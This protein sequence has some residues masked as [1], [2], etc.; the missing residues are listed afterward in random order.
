MQVNTINPSVSTA[1][2]VAT[3]NSAKSNGRLIEYFSLNYNTTKS[4]ANAKATSENSFVAFL[5]VIGNVAMTAL[6]AVG[7]TFA[8]ALKGSFNLGVSPLNF[9]YSL[10]K[11]EEKK[12]TT[13]EVAEEAPAPSAPVLEEKEEAEVAPVATPELETVEE[14]K[15]VTVELPKDSPRSILT[16]AKDRLAFEGTR[17]KAGLNF[18]FTTGK[19]KTVYAANQAAKAVKF[20]G[21]TTADYAK[22]G[23]SYAAPAASKVRST[24]SDLGSTAQE[25]TARMNGIQE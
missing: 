11:G 8:N 24:L 18:V 13:T 16:Q 6:S 17:A 15:D 3:N 5:Q 19:S 20:A 10:V 9:V 2:A 12:E 4:Y 25:F 21:Q 22:A 14:P 1:E 23:Y 7:E